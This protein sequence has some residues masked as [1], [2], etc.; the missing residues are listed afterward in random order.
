MAMKAACLKHPPSSVLL[1]SVILLTALTAS[2]QTTNLLGLNV[3]SEVYPGAFRPSVGVTFE[4]QLG[5][6]SGFE[7][8]LYYRTDV[9]R[10][11]T[12]YTDST[13][14]RLYRFTI[15]HRY[16]NL[17]IL[18]KFYSRFLHFSAGPALDLFTGWQQKKDDL[19]AN[20]TGFDVSPKLDIGFL[21]K[22]GKAIL[23]NNRIILEPEIRYAYPRD[24][25]GLG[26]G[27][28]IKYNAFDLH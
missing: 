20:I 2:G 14:T 18:Y 27:V 1:F 11:F 3:N 26:V 12:N 13:G 17:P 10:G 21:V 5:K 25:G 23:L 9:T 22:A 8:G 15:A 28:A 7:T 6:H 19:P 16:M 4:S 24:F